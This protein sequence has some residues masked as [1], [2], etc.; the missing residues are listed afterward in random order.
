M[1]QPQGR[2]VVGEKMGNKIAPKVIR[3]HTLQE[4]RRRSI[5]QLEK[6]IDPEEV[7]QHELRLSPD[8]RPNKHCRSTL[9]PP[10]YI[11]VHTC[12]R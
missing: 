11:C 1:A 10:H 6:G 4:A 12:V 2:S 8:T 7:W 3:G 5:I 9:P